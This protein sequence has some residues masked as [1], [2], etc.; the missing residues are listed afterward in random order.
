MIFV[1]VFCL[2]FFIGFMF[3]KKIPDGVCVTKLV[4]GKL[5]SVGDC[6]KN[7]GFEI[8]KLIKESLANKQQYKC[9]VTYKKICFRAVVYDARNVTFNDAKAI[10]KSM[11]GKPAN[12]Y[13]LKHYQ[14]LLPYLRSLIHFNNQLLLSGGKPITIATEVCYPSFPVSDASWN[15]VGVYVNKDPEDTIQGMFNIAPS[16]N[17]NGVIC[18]I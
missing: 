18:E 6:K 13:D 11:N 9:D 14:L 4:K 12:I 2:F 7:D 5:V 10:C 15:N 3:G 1:K 8:A 17:R 16:Y